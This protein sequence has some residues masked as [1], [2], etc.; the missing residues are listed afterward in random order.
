MGKI[1]DSVRIYGTGTTTSATLQTFNGVG[2][3]TFVVKDNGDVDVFGK[4]KSTLLQVTSGATTG[5]ILTA[6][7]NQG[8]VGWLP[9][10]DENI[11]E[12]APVISIQST[13]PVS[14]VDGDRYLVSGGTGVWSTKNNQVAE[15][16]TSNWVYTVPVLDN[17]TFVTETLSTYRFNGTSWAPYRGTAILQNG[18]RVN[19]SI[20]IGSNDYQDVNIRTSG[21]TKFHVNKTGYVGVNTITPVSNFQVSQATTDLGT[22]SATAGV[23]I[24]SANTQIN[25]S[26]T[27]FRNVF[28]VGDTITS[29]GFTLTIQQITS[30][31]LMYTN[32]NTGAT[33]SNQNYTLVGG[34]RLNVIGNGRVGINTSV[35]TAILQIPRQGVYK[36]ANQIESTSV[37]F[38][39]YT[40]L[41]GSSDF[42]VKNDG[43]A[44]FGTSDT[45]WYTGFPWGYNPLTGFS[46]Y[47]GFISAATA[48]D[49][50]KKISWNGVQINK[51]I[52]LVGT[53]YISFGNLNGT[54]GSIYAT[55]VYSN[56]GFTFNDA[57]PYGN[58]GFIYKYP[59]N[60]AAYNYGPLSG[61][62][63]YPP[64][65][66]PNG[67]YS[68]ID[69]SYSVSG[70]RNTRSNSYTIGVG[71]GATTYNY[72]F[73]FNNSDGN[74]TGNLVFN[75]GNGNA[76]ML[77]GGGGVCNGGGNFKVVTNHCG[78][79][80]SEKFSVNNSG[81][82]DI[83][84]TQ[85]G[86]SR[87]SIGNY[88][89]FGAG[90][91]NLIKAQSLY[92][93]GF[94]WGESFLVDVKGYVGIGTFSPTAL[95]HIKGPH[96][97]PWYTPKTGL[98]IN[99]NT[100]PYQP[101]T[102]KIDDTD[103]NPFFYITDVGNVGVNVTNPRAK[104]H[105]NNV[106]TGHTVLF[107]D[108]T[109]PDST[110]FVIDNSGNVGIGLTTPS[111][112]L[113]VSGKT[114]TTTLQVTSN[115]TDGYVLTSD[116]S[117]NATWQQ[118]QDSTSLGTGLTIHFSGKTI[119]NLPS[120]PVSGNISGNT[121]NAKFGMIQKIYHQS[122]VEPT[123]PATWKLVGEG[124]YFTNEL[125]II[126]AE[127]VEPTWIEYWII[128]QQ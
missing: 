75:A 82:V 98:T 37:N 16:L 60:P 81:N 110:P 9:F 90:S 31:T 49:V 109:N 12:L 8:N 10:N 32:L 94:N 83:G 19:N 29:S 33:F 89:N 57:Y 51:P 56:N 46:D 76:I 39:N 74:N 45:Y 80:W 92:G 84:I 38:T 116:V 52:N 65:M 114:K 43:F 59:T 103:G 117:G 78:N 53:N 2:T 54:P 100:S 36:D 55:G 127:Y 79:N 50:S 34:P 64:G 14:N 88:R 97:N 95:V 104:F 101:Y 28:R 44:G 107:E 27:R 124:V 35:P 13:P 120:S 66:N 61:T 26:G 87:L 17:T 77:C 42:T 69:N 93:K 119:F 6:L 15:W 86:D 125:N 40:L 63:I 123:F 67:E 96:Q 111:E 48:Y 62:T 20:N 23:G 58:G 25:G 71:T 21:T 102:L 72:R 99:G 112:K 91:H 122:A 121:T 105:I 7:D 24:Y 3:N 18:N 4:T 68:L 70:P 85:N 113:E 108:N 118:P 115:P 11:K 73:G 5:Y 128:Q 126:Y 106:T 1:F 47:F 22:I 30:D 41:V